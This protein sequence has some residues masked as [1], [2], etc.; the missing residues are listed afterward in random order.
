VHGEA[1]ALLAGD[2]L[3]TLGL[4]LLAEAEGIDPSR[5]ARIV[6]VVGRAAGSS[7][8]VGGQVL[9]LAAEGR[10]PEDLREVEEIHER[11]TGALLAASVL[12]GAIAAGA[13]PEDE[14]RLGL[15]GR[16]L[17]FA[18]QIAD[19]ILDV[20]GEAATAGKRTGKDADRGKAT[21]PAL[22]GVEGAR[23][24]ALRLAREAGDSLPYD[25][26]GGLLRAL[27]QFVVDR[28]A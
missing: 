25:T 7:G 2:A 12:A 3:L 9:D 26:D 24:L 15:Y 14:K 6:S 19:D 18:F 1:L 28:I 20:T 10:A 21:V 4:T 8:M 27:A 5:R 23:A 13:L 11:K 16:K 17:G 22:L